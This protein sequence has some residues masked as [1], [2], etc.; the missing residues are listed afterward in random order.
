MNHP[1]LQRRVVTE[2]QTEQGEEDQEERKDREHA[3]VGEQGRQR[4]AAVFDVFLRDAD[5]EGGRRMT[6]LKGIEAT[7]EFLDQDRPFVAAPSNLMEASKVDETSPFAGR[8]GID[9]A[10][11]L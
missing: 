1:M 6:L 10:L 5:D 7:N 3:V 4:R 2:D 11:N 9:S 8:Q